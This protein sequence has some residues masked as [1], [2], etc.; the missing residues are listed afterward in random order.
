MSQVQGPASLI[1]A[2]W[3]WHHCTQDQKP[4]GQCSGIKRTQRS[5]KRDQE[6]PEVYKRDQKNPV[7][8]KRDRKN[9]V[10]YER[11]QENPVVYNRDQANPAVN[12]K[13]SREPECC[14]E[15]YTK[16]SLEIPSGTQINFAWECTDNVVD[17]SCGRADQE[18]LKKLYQQHSN[19]HLKCVNEKKA[20]GARCKFAYGRRPQ[21]QARAYLGCI[22]LNNRG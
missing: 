19:Q 20:P 12:E 18:N 8:Y 9:P 10:V 11:D 16:Q 4:C 2:S 1:Q 17:R 13:G 5:I 15:I 7:V 3:K 6:N 22:H 14:E 21:A